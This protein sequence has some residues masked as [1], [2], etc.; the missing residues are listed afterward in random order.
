M[1]VAV[2]AKQAE[3]V[4]ILIAAV[5]AATATAVASQGEKGAREGR[6]G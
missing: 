5:T 6:A 1:R 4:T 3:A 2:T